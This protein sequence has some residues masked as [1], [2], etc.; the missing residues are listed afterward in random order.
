MGEDTH[1]DFTALD[2]EKRKNKFLLGLGLLENLI[3]TRCC[4]SGS[5][6]IG[7]RNGLELPCCLAFIAAMRQ[8]GLLLGFDESRQYRSRLLLEGATSSLAVIARTDGL[9]RSGAT[10][11]FW[12]SSM[13]VMISL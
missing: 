12:Q 7:L 6:K 11:N 5:E 8:V 4:L 10:T 13:V 9:H 1:P 3:R 2:P